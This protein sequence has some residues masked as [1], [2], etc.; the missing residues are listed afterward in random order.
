[1]STIIITPQQEGE[2][3]MEVWLKKEILVKLASPLQIFPALR[4]PGVLILSLSGC[5]LAEAL[6]KTIDPLVPILLLQEELIT[7]MMWNHCLWKIVTTHD[8]FMTEILR[9]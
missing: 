4:G 1:M 2:A 9:E 6:R 8:H 5:R 3:R 7:N